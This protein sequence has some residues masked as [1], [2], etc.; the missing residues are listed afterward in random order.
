MHTRKCDVSKAHFVA[1]P[2]LSKVVIDINHC[3]ETDL[4]HVSA[5]RMYYAD[6]LKAV[7]EVFA[8]TNLLENK[9]VHNGAKISYAICNPLISMV[10]ECFSYSLKLKNLEEGEEVEDVR[11]EAVLVDLMTLWNDHP[12]VET[13]T[14]SLSPAS[15][16]A[17]TPMG[18]GSGRHSI[19][20]AM[21]QASKADYSIYTKLVAIVD[22]KKH[23]LQH[24]SLGTTVPSKL[25]THD[26]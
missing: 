4:N 1:S 2:P 15:T 10:C 5:T 8:R 21:P 13:A 26:L 11:E 25:M 12:T 9:S 14:E 24:R 18:L 20:G 19:G 22:A 6:I 7:A 3:L 17:E 16:S 23:I